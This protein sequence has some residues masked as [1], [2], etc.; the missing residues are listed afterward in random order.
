MSASQAGLRRLVEVLHE[1]RIPFVIGG[2]LASSVHGVPRATMDVDLVVDLKVEQV[3][4][5][6]DALCA[7][8]YADAAA[9]E[10]AVRTGRSFN[11]IHYASS[12]KFDLFPLGA[13]PFQQAEFRRRV[14]VK[15]DL[16]GS[17]PLELPVVTAEDSILSKLDG[18]RRG[19]EASSRQWEDVL[20]VMRT[21]GNALDWEYLHRWSR[22]LGVEDLLK[23]A[24]EEAA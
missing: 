23:R 9:L 24:G 18:Y 7:D 12:Y 20:G 19:G 3:E 22:H 17:G 11:L 6:A 21:S 5:L 14:S 8:F 10:Q 4:P 2:S 16:P 1:L 15:V 13:D